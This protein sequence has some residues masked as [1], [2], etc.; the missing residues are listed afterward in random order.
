M[1]SV[2]SLTDNQALDSY[3]K[4]VLFDF[5]LGGHHGSYI[6]HLI[7]YW[8]KQHFPGSLEIV[9]RPEF[10][11]LHT[12]PVEL[13]SHY[14]SSNL[15]FTAITQDEAY[16]IDQGQSSFDRFI[17]KFKRWELFRKYATYLGAN[18]ALFLYFD[19]CELPL[20]F[21]AKAPCPFSGIYFRPTFHY[22]EFP[23]YH[24]SGKERIQQIR[25]RIILNRILKNPQLKTIFCLDPFA[26]KHLEQMSGS[27]KVTYLP[28]PVQ[29]KNTPSI[30]PEQLQQRL[31]I[32][33]NRKIF[34]LFGALD[35]RKGIDQL[36]EA[37]ALLSNEV[38]TKICLVLAGGTHPNEQ[39]RIRDQIGKTC[40]NK[41]V[42]I[43]EDY[44]FIPEAEVPAYFQ[45]ADVVLAPY[46]RHVGMSGILLLAAAAG[47]PVLSSNYGLMGELVRRYQLGIAIDS[48]SSEG[49]AKA[50]SCSL[51]EAAETWGDRAQMKRFVEQNSVEQYTRTIFQHL[52]P[53]FYCTGEES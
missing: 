43:V 25:E 52:Y 32:Q 51:N 28:D 5:D 39:A 49:I 50:L 10:F 38:C 40:A 53:A 19:S 23:R 7:E 41:S 34:L 44:R 42:Q 46:Q 36:L 35:G 48:S 20:A 31:E 3:P 47:K 6:Q 13:A 9:V 26:V 33:S 27:V 15:K 45:L 11:D 14:Q 22:R 16:S 1:I 4:L 8:Y 12:D 29:L 24:P 37:V 21:G 18:H 2:S 17:R 30:T